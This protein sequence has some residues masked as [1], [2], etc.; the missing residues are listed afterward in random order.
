VNEQEKSKL[1]VDVALHKVREAI[2]TG[3]YPDYIDPRQRKA[4]AQDQH[5]YAQNPAFPREH[6]QK[7]S[8]AKSY[9]EL[10]ASDQ[11]QTVIKKVERYL[12][13]VPSQTELQ[14]L[15]MGM[16]HSAEK[17][18]QLEAG[19]EQ[20]LEQAAIDIVLGLPEFEVARQAYESG[21]LKIVAKLH[22]N[23]EFETNIEAP[24]PAENIGL[25][26][27]QIAQELQAEQ[28]KRRFINLMVQ[29]SAINKNF[30]FHMANETL[31]A[32]DPEL[33]KLYGTI[34]STAELAYWTLPEEYQKAMMAGGGAAGKV[35]LSNEESGITIHAEAVVFPVL[36]QEIV[37]GLMEYISYDPDEDPETHNHVRSQTD[38]LSNELWDIRVG[39][40]V[41]RH[42]LS[43]IGQDNQ[44]LMPYIYQHLVSLSPNEF[45]TVAQHIV[46]NTP[47][48]RDWINKIVAE[49]QADSEEPSEP[50][51]F[52]STR[53]ELGGL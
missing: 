43:A 24:E 21:E 32:I 39:P 33:M 36:I 27:D 52:E 9:A 2:D 53:Q 30:A 35:K 28:H 22:P 47:Q 37:K 18:M 40:A 15:F 48:G 34:M 42:I 44:R 29:G 5:P 25:E 12:G 4:L 3:A 19:H 49:I 51:Q 38:T 20:E 23:V 50:N 45:S 13:R 14:Q 46:K 10:A 17:A 1:L 11:Y 31:D 16:Q 41:W 6:G 8:K 7:G 26:V